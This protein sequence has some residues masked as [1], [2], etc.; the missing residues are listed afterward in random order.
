MRIPLRTPLAEMVALRKRRAAPWLAA[1]GVR[2]G[3]C[4]GVRKG[5]SQRVLVKGARKDVRK[6]ARHEVPE[7]IYM[8]MYIYI[9]KIYPI[10]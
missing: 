4:K 6:G 7:R 8:Y 2:K 5:C 1:S 3:V 9:Y 10:N